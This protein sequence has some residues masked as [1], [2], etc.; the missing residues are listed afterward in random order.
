MRPLVRPDAGPPEGKV[1]A[2][3]ESS[4][5][6]SES[7]GPGDSRAWP[8]S[9]NHGDRGDPR[10]WQLTSEFPDG[11]IGFQGTAFKTEK[12]G[13]HQTQKSRE[14]KEGGK[15]EPAE[16]DISL[17]STESTGTRSGTL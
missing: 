3:P 17:P 4:C 7:R 1:R 11:S 6:G 13:P 16:S 9:P 5:E 12:R 15:K 2:A 14:G 10:G 8:L